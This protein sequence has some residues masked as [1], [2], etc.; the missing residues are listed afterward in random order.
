MIMLVYVDESEVP[1]GLPDWTNTAVDYTL[2]VFQIVP[3]VNIVVEI[4]A[5]MSSNGE[6]SQ[7]LILLLLIVPVG[8]YALPVKNKSII[9]KSNIQDSISRFPGLSTRQKVR[10]AIMETGLF[11]FTSLIIFLFYQSSL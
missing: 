10:N 3:L 11:V 6:T 7:N 4:L 5:N 9:Y 1:E 2:E 8:L